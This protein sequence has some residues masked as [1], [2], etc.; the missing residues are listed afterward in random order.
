MVATQIKQHSSTTPKQIQHKVA[1]IA[2][3]LNVGKVAAA[4]VL[5][6]VRFLVRYA[7]GAH[8]NV[9]FSICMC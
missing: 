5:Q 1:S 7:R 6:G 2:V 3:I 9:C 4:K 8:K